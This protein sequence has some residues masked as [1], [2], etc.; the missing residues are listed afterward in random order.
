[1][2]KLALI[3]LVA[4]MACFQAAHASGVDGASKIE[5]VKCRSGEQHLL[6]EV[7]YTFKD[8]TTATKKV[9]MCAPVGFVIGPK[10]YQEQNDN[11]A[12]MA[13]KGRLENGAVS[14]G[15]S[16]FGVAEPEPQDRSFLTY[17]S[18]LFRSGQ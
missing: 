8:S 4:F 12:Y 6:L 2:K 1:M 18:E 7:V 10:Q 17:I 14:A 13:Q 15:V 9:F 16:F 3:I 11:F 5:N